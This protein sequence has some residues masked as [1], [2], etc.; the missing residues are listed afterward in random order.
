MLHLFREKGL[1][2]L[3]SIQSPF[4]HCF[5][6]SASSCVHSWRSL[7][8]PCCSTADLPPPTM[9][10]LRSDSA[11]KLSALFSSPPMLLSKPYL[12]IANWLAWVWE[13]TQELRSFPFL[14][15]THR[16]LMSSPIQYTSHFTCSALRNHHEFSFWV[17]IHTT[18]L[19]FHHWKK[20]KYKETTKKSDMQK[21]IRIFLKKIKTHAPVWEKGL[22]F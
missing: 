5:H 3:G 8:G 1:H 21:N 14:H 7:G 15:H 16:K 13:S 2:L 17:S 6:L 12:N 18:A 22:I 4:H 9:L 10:W 11:C 19:A 20:R